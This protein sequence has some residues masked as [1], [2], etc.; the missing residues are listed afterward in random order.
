MGMDREFLIA[1]GG[2]GL[3]LL[4]MIILTDGLKELTAHKLRRLL[5]RFTK[6]PLR[7]AA[8]GALT[9][10]IVQSSSATTVIAVGFVGSG[11]LTFSQG[12]GIIFGANIGTTITG[13]IVAIL[14]FKLHLG[15]VALPL[16]LLGVLLKLFGSRQLRHV[17]WALAG[18]SLLFVGIDAMQQGMASL[19]GIVTPSIFPEDTIAGRLQLVL[20]GALITLV[21]QSSSAGVATALVALYAGAITFPQAAALVIGMDVGTTFTAALATLGGSTA[22]RRTGFAHVI[23]NLMTGTMAFFMLGPYA[24]FASTWIADGGA[25]NAQISLVAFHTMFNIIGVLLALPFAGL[26]ARLMIWLVPEKGPPLLRRLDER[27]LPDSAAAVDAT[28]ATIRDIATRLLGIVAGLLDPK[29]VD[30]PVSSRLSEI[31]QALDATRQFLAQIQTEPSSKSAHARHLATMHAF[32]HLQ[33]LAHRCG[34]GARTR[35][36]HT[37]R[38]L[39]ELSSVLRNATLD[40]LDGQVSTAEE[41]TLERLQKNLL[42]QHQQ[43]RSRMVET[44]TQQI[45]DT[46]T[47]LLRLD[48]VRWLHRVSYHLWRVIHHLRRAEETDFPL[49]ESDEF[50]LEA[51]LD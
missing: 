44:A 35:I 49:P 33:R 26:F 2:V 11:L 34:Q 5:V 41:E 29:E 20:I 24:S 16:L 21:T 12:L 46:D 6:T 51:Q 50:A 37:E 47:I 3:F 48:A 18:F 23:Y 22:T 17:G 27:L 36:L 7:G 32:D 15:T 1:F 25:G 40:L 28:A 4:G 38:G 42:Q 30:R 10:A 14:G 8:A 13:W 19:E 43:Y 31:E 9:T 45:V 39:Q